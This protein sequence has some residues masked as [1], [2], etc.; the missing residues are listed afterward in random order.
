MSANSILLWVVLIVAICG[1]Y[2]ITNGRELFYGTGND[3]ISLQSMLWFV[4]NSIDRLLLTIII[5]R[6]SKSALSIGLII[7][8]SEKL[9]NEFGTPWKLGFSE[10]AMWVIAIGVCIGYWYEKNKDNDSTAKTK[11]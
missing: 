6:Y 11:N 1:N 4:C 2:Q 10:V 5:Y 9:Y 7:L 3:S 8:A